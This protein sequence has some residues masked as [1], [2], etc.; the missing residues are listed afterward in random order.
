M[1]ERWHHKPGV[2]G[3]SPTL[4]TKYGGRSSIG[5]SIG[6]SSQGL[7]V[8]AS[9][10]PPSPRRS[11]SLTDEGGLRLAE[12]LVKASFYFELWINET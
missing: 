11:P 3:S 5:Q 9:S 8:R 6:L 10:P 12:V 4:G 7:R 2:V 1:V